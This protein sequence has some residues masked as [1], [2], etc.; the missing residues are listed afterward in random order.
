M[1]NQIKWANGSRWDDRMPQQILEALVSDPWRENIYLLPLLHGRHA[2]IQALPD[3][4]N[5]GKIMV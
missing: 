3:I 5:K 1:K 4:T 2:G